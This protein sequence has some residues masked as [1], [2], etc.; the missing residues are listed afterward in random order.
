VR[1]DLE[2]SERIL[3][4]RLR[5]QRLTG[6]PCVTPEAAV[7]RL[8]GVQAQDYRSATWSVGAR[9][10]G[11][12]DAD[13][14]QAFAAGRILRT[15][16]LRPTWHF[17]L[18]ADIRWLLTATAP[19]ITAR[20]RRRY[21]E[22]GLAATARDRAAAAFAAA[23]R[24]GHALTRAEMAEVAADAGVSPEGQR[25]PYLLMSAELAAV[26]CGGPRRGKQHTSMLLEERAPGAPDLPRDA[27]LCELAVRFFAGHGP[28]TEK[29]L[30]WWASL[31][32]A[33]VRS[34]IGRA[35]DR[36][37][38][39]EADGLVLWSSADESP[40]DAGPAAGT[41]VVH[42]VQGYD[43]YIMGYA[44]TRRLLARPGSSWAAATPPAGRLV[45]LLDGRVAG[46]WRRTFRRARVAV[47]AELID[48]WDDAGRAALA[49][50]A[51]RYGAFVGRAV[52]LVVD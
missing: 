39:E 11:A 49:A 44:D 1:V 46:F 28:A 5:A 24:G 17:V 14:E 10:A 37:R 19:R 38:C 25:L 29:D 3:A 12:T 18:P 7:G 36:L 40:G 21:E 23:L 6:A 48:A 2:L 27:A 35:G 43:E 47:E 50:E 33:E 41:P 45:V 51:A 42:L 52:D 34:A 26:V 20:D 15:H 9:A 30:A 13:V 32:L 31:T 16:V 4:R 8:L 22:L